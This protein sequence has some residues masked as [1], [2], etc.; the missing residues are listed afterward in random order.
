MRCG[1]AGM[2]ERQRILERL[3]ARIVART[4][5]HYYTDKMDL[6][7]MILTRRME[8]CHC[9]RP[10]EYLSR[11][12]DPEG[13]E[14]EWRALESA[15]TIGETFFFRYAEQFQALERTILPDLLTR[16]RPLRTI[17][18]WSVG[19][20]NGAEPYS[21][22]ILLRRLLQARGES[23]WTIDIL[24]TDISAQALE[25]AR[26]GDYGAWSL[27][28]VGA[29]EQSQW[30]RQTECGRHW[31]LR[32]VYRR[33]VRFEYGN[34]MDLPSGGGPAGPFDLILCRN[35]LIYFEAAQALELVRVLAGRLSRQGW[36]LLGHS[37]PVAEC[38]AFLETVTFPGTQAFRIPGCRPGPAPPPRRRPTAAPV[39]LPSRLPAVSPAAWLDVP[40][41]GVAEGGGNAQIT[42]DG[43]REL[44]D[45]GAVAEARDR[46]RAALAARPLDAGLHFL[47]GMLADDPGDAE[48]GFRRTLYLD[49]DHV[50]AHVHLARLLREGGKAE[51]GRRLLRHARMLL[52]KATPDSP[53]AE[54]G[55]L[56]AGGLLRLIRP[57][58]T[59]RTGDGV[60]DGSPRMSARMPTRMQRGVS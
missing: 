54:G 7:D 17:R 59:E 29:A 30:F 34:I 12:A 31:I 39:P 3:A 41:D 57:D 46:C 13:G 14:A 11:L 60:P 23:D 45:G 2:P 1:G 33:M 52:R 35:V 38:G 43:V 42:A 19:C 51:Q 50:L 24:G 55:G 44:A 26:A 8:A 53:L 48:E 10:M 22:A 40:V 9:D 16:L 47:S 49:R 21:L 20:S 18:I 58:G 25:R 27:R 6:L 56:T 15:V 5:L 4:G 32:D 36:L 37:D 28:D